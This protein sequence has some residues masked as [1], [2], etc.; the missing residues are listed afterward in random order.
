MAFKGIET[1][2]AF[3]ALSNDDDTDAPEQVVVESKGDSKSQPKAQHV[4]QPP[5]DTPKP[6]RRQSPPPKPSKPAR[7]AQLAPALDDVSLFPALQVTKTKRRL[8]FG[9]M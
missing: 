1:T 5:M 7:P 4:S 9:S 8:N 3:G 6:Y 2:N